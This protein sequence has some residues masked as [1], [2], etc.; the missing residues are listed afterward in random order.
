MTPSDSAFWQ[1]ESEVSRMHGVTLAVIDGPAPTAAELTDHLARRVPLVPRL[2][3]RVI[4]VPLELERPVWVDDPEFDLDHHV[5]VTSNPIGMAGLSELVSLIVSEPI[6]RSRPL[7]N[8][9]MVTDLPEDQWALVSKVHHSLI[10]GVSGTDPL[11]VLVDGSFHDAPI[12]PWH[13]PRLPRRDEIARQALNDL[14][15]N[16]IEQYRAYRAVAMRER[17][18][19]RRLTGRV[20]AITAPDESGLRGP[21]G[22][23]RT[24][25]SVAVPSEWSR[26]ARRH[27][28]LSKHELVLVL[29]ASGLRDLMTARDEGAARQPDIRAVVPVS[30]ADDPGGHGAV[31][32]TAPGGRSTLSATVVELPTG[33]PTLAARVH[34]VRETA[35]PGATDVGASALTQLSG[36]AAP[37][38]ASLGLREATRTGVA[39]GD[40]QTVVVNVPGPR[41]FLTLLGRRINDA[42]LVM[43]LP[44]RVRVSVGVIS[45]AGLMTFGITADRDAL[46]DARVVAGGIQRAA[47]E[48]ATVPQGD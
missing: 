41:E 13:P 26:A 7:W 27:H 31:R 19:W 14:A 28:D 36:F 4:P 15:F 40:V 6:D 43:P 39:D 23:R 30:V 21:V 10:D 33:A 44:A 11:A 34:Q 45:Y 3:Q 25:A 12:V 18:R 35:A 17:R 24:W 42:Y 47:R 46:P 37:A 29:V 20:A 8:I 32:G 5:V 38:L 16:P 9:T 1:M 2:R 22:A 48:L